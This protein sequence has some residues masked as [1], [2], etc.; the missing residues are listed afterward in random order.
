MGS[1]DNHRDADTAWER[2]AQGGRAH[3]GAPGKRGADAPGGRAHN[4]APGGHRA[5]ALG[6][7]AHDDALGG[8]GADGLGRRN[9]WLDSR[10]DRALEAQRL[11]EQEAKLEAHR[12]FS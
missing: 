12:D 6:G 8:W 4:G 1:F 2:D 5:N 11:R 3:D 9:H 10:V 7:R